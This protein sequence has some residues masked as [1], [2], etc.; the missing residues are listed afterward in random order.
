MREYEF[1][2]EY[3]TKLTFIV[4]ADSYEEAVEKLEDKALSEDLGSGGH[5]DWVV[6]TCLETGKRIYLS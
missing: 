4:S 5:C 2:V 1:D 3:E 6:A